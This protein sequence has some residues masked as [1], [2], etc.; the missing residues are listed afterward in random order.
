MGQYIYH[1]KSKTRF[2]SVNKLCGHRFTQ[3]KYNLVKNL[4]K[5]GNKLSTSHFVN[6]K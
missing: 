3:R 5:T 1:L 6:F 4:E 2:L